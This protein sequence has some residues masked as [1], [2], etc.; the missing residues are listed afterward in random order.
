MEKS[1]SPVTRRACGL[2]IQILQ[3]AQSD[4]LQKHGPNTTRDGER[5][6]YLRG[7]DRMANIKR[8]PEAV[9]QVDQHVG[10]AGEAMPGKRAGAT[11]LAHGSKDVGRCLQTF[12]NGV[13]NGT[14][15]P[16]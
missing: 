10:L 8:L 7:L 5:D 14:S 15:G 4:I 9:E 2:S 1:R 13:R 16:G 12:E 11:G 3:E 6:D